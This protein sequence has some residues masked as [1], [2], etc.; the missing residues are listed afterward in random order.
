[1]NKTVIYSSDLILQNNLKNPPSFAM[2]ITLF[3]KDIRYLNPS[4]SS[5]Q[6]VT[7]KQCSN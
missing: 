7:S 5:N 4:L 6:I 2:Y 3:G 1:M